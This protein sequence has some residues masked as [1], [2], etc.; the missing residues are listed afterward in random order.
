MTNLETLDFKHPTVVAGIRSSEV[1][2][3]ET[4]LAIVTVPTRADTGEVVC[5][6]SK[7]RHELLGEIAVGPD[8]V[9]AVAE[10]EVSED[11]TPVLKIDVLDSELPP[12]AL[13]PLTKYTEEEVYDM[14]PEQT[15]VV[16]EG[17]SAPIP[18]HLIAAA[19]IRQIAA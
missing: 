7:T 6:V 13:R 8:S 16:I 4:D 15:E 18:A 5:L 12:Q 14:S 19:A 11:G 3:D 9:K 1:C 10:S 2:E 17:L